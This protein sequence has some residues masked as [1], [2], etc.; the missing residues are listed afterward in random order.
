M[1]EN[2]SSVA[3]FVV[4]PKV[5]LLD[6]GGPAHIF[7]EAVGYGA[8]LKLVFVGIG[9]EPTDVVSTSGLSFTS[10]TDFRSVSLE[11]GDIVFVPGLDAG[12]LND[13]PFLVSI[14][15]FLE[16]LR[17]QYA[18]GATV[19]SVCTG[20]FLL[21]HSGLLDGRDCT[22]HWKYFSLMQQTFPGTRVLKGRLF[23]EDGRIYSSA[24]V[25]SG[26]DLSLFA[27]EKRYGSAFAAAVAREVVVYLRREGDDPQISIF[28]QYRNHLEDRIHLVQEYLVKHLEENVLLE[29]LA[30]RVHMSS[31]NLTRLFKATT[32]ITI[33]AY[34]ERLTVEQA[35]RAL[36]EG[37]TVQQ[38]A[39]A[40]G[41]SSENQL[42]S[43]IKKHLGQLPSAFI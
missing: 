12:L 29:N 37:Q 40:C 30:A 22:T 38:A 15:P 10:L 13:K 34:R 2:S 14:A 7:Y 11:E 8:G 31:R 27:L 1:R 4:P 26:I 36:R 39:L 25:A 9:A 3:V 17:L 42:R 16:W 43:L 35:M 18:Q 33:G 6:I 20:A 23:V 41:Y 5:H 28:L 21:G 19:C 24:G 32:G